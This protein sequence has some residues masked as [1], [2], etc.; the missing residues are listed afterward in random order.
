MTIADLTRVRQAKARIAIRKAQTTELGSRVMTALAWENG[1]PYLR[2]RAIKRR[3]GIARS[4]AVAKRSRAE[5]S[6]HEDL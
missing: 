2:V 6:E 1:R 5:R 4:R 3:A